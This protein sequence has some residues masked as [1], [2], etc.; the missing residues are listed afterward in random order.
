M[1]DEDEANESAGDEEEHSEGAD[2]E[3]GGLFARFAAT[4]ETAL[5]DNRDRR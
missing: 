2:E 5:T 3:D 1:S 4:I